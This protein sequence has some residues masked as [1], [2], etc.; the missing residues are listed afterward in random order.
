MGKSK[1]EWLNYQTESLEEDGRQQWTAE[2]E[3]FWHESTQEDKS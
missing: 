2:M 3:E 1:K